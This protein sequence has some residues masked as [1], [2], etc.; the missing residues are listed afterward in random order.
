M[1]SRK[2]RADPAS[3]ADRA[4]SNGWVSGQHAERD[5]EKGLNNYGSEVL[6]KQDAVLDKFA[7]W[8]WDKTHRNRPFGEYKACDRPTATTLRARVKEFKA[9]FTRYTGNEMNDEDT[10]EINHWLKHVLPYE[11]GSGVKDIEMPKFN[12]K[13]VDLDRNLKA[14]WTRRDFAELGVGGCS[15]L[16]LNTR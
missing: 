2:R 5:K 14:L 3:V 10:E 12:Y 11:K 15:R 7:I 9:G 6:A 4:K 1:S 13:P 8:S 16:V